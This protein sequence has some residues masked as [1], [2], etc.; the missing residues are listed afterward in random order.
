ANTQ[1][2]KHGPRIASKEPHHHHQT[3]ARGKTNAL[4]FKHPVEFSRNKHTPELLTEVI[5]PGALSFF[6]SVLLV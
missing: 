1:P 4:A 5:R 2:T 3:V 6:V